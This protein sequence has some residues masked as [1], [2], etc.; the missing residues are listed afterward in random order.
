MRQHFSKNVFTDE[1]VKKGW[2]Q[3]KNRPESELLSEIKISIET[4][5]IF[6]LYQPVVEPKPPSRAIYRHESYYQT[7]G[8]L[9]RLLALNGCKSLMELVDKEK[10]KP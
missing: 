4:N 8:F 10:K 6:N 7:E 2:E 9:D 1:Q 5:V 3:W